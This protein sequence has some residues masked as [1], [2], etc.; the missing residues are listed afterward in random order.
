MLPL[1]NTINI[2]TEAQIRLLKNEIKL[3]CKTFIFYFDSLNNNI[4]PQ[5]LDTRIDDFKDK[6]I[7]NV[8]STVYQ[9]KE[10]TKEL[11]RIWYYE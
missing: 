2:D 7:I 5:C 3:K 4:S 6:I 8:T 1:Q 11:V 10:K 9:E